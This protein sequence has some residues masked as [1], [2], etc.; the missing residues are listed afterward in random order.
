MKT[1]STNQLRRKV[2]L[3]QST[4]REV[5]ESRDDLTEI[6][7]VQDPEDITKGILDITTDKNLDML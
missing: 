4:T 1:A 5:V 6:L 3:N 2:R 7:A